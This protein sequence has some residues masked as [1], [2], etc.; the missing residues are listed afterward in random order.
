MREK[1]NN[2]LNPQIGFFA[3][4]YYGYPG[5]DYFQSMRDR[6][7]GFNVIAGVR[8]SW[9]LSPLYDRKNRLK[10]LDI[11]DRN[12]ENERET[13][14]FNNR[15]QT[16]AQQKE[17]EGLKKVIA[18]DSKIVALRASVRKAAESQMKNGIIDAT[19][20]IAKITD[21]NNARLTKEYNEILLL[22]NIY[23]L[24]YILNQ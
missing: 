15:L 6:K 4:A 24:K 22:Q 5:L 3:S 8:A 20:L 18:D 17:I 16:S 19:D 14:L 13:F 11:S 12:I 1:I 21:E 7:P 9:S 10:L 2:L 23:K